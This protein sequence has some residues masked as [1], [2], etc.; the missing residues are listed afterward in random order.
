MQGHKV[1]QEILDC[2]SPQK[3]LMLLLD[4]LPHWALPDLHYGQRRE[5]LD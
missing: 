3:H 4:F 1:L 5:P 2:L